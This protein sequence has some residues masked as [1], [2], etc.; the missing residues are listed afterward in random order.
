M[1][2][3]V[4]RASTPGSR[5]RRRRFGAARKT[6]VILVAIVVVVATLIYSQTL[7]PAHAAA[8]KSWVRLGIARQPALMSEIRANLADVSVPVSQNQLAWIS[9]GTLNEV[10]QVNADTG[11]VY[12][13]PIPLPTN[14]SPVALAYWRP[15]LGYT[16]A[17]NNDPLVAVLS[18]NTSSGTDYVTFIDALTKEVLS[19]WPPRSR[20]P[21]STTWLP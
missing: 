6:V 19:N 12:G 11:E 9:L 16:T 8:A 13:S 21:P 4:F 14:D 1:G 5:L 3:G 2:I 7:S 17:A 20:P 15:N 18:N 10:E